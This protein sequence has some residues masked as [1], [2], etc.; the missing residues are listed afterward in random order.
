MQREIPRVLS[1][2]I[3]ALLAW[4]GIVWSQTPGQRLLMTRAELQGLIEAYDQNTVSSANHSGIRS[5]ARHEVELIRSRLID[6]D[7]QIGDQV[8]VG[9]QGEAELTGNFHVVTGPAGVA[10]R[11]P[12]IGDIPLKGVL[13]SEVEGH[14]RNE[15]SRYIRDPV[16]HARAMIRVS[17]FEGVARPGFYPAAAEDLLTD[18][19]M[20]AGGPSARARL[21][22]VRIERGRDRI[23]EGEALQKAITEGRTLDQLSLVA[24]DR[25]IVPERGDRVWLTALQIGALVVTS[26]VA[27]IRVF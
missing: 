4:A 15:I 16:V 20:A 25:I 6:G 13:R 24:G 17:V 1:V 2:F 8:S 12:I 26:T 11:L 7:F 22:R 14:L 21:D 10:L 3:I 19:L 18:V 9:V 27:L 5:L 23:W